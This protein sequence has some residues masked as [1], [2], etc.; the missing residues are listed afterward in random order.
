[1]DAIRPV[2]P[3]HLDVVIVGA[4]LSGIGCAVHLS[5]RCPDH[6]Y[7]ILEARERMGGTWDLFRYPGIRSDSDMYTL[8]YAFRPWTDGKAIAD[9]P[10]ILKYIE[11]TAREFSVDEKI[12]Y[13]LRLERASW[14]TEDAKWTLFLREASTG[15]VRRMTCRFLL[16]CTGYYDYDQAHAPQFEG[17]GDFA[18]RVV[19]P[20]FW[21]EDIDYAGK[22]VVVI[23]SGATAMT[24]VPSLAE[25]AEHVTMLQRSPTYVVAAPDTDAVA[26]F[27]RRHLSEK[28]AYDI[29]RWKNV[30]RTIAL[31]KASRRFPKAMKKLFIYGVKKA[32]GEDYDVEKHFTPSYNPWDQRLCLVPNG[33]LFEAIKAGTASVATD[34]IERFTERG[35]RLQSGEE[36]EADLIVTATGLKVRLF[37]GAELSVDGRAITPNDTMAYRAMMVSD[38]PNLAFAVGYTNAS[39][40]LKIDL[41]ADYVA[42]LLD[43]MDANGYDICVPERDPDM[44]QAP[45]LDFDANYIKR[46]LGELPQAGKKHPW[47]IFENYLLDRVTLNNAR[48]DDGIMK[49]SKRKVRAVV[50]PQQTPAASTTQRQTVA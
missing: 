38:V 12:R 28:T 50:R 43:H 1:M 35:V 3:E 40:T 2:D 9:G 37:G 23:G 29:T 10:S 24:L 36:L 13:G 46:A 19:H 15:E 41:V 31:Y 47:R 17:Q 30:L 39:W 11:D 16:A 8:G 42:R 44:E 4:G 6:R 7:A 48:F 25:Q 34:H 27:L 5:K 32:L 21:T 22:K 33:D 14:S 26:D 18:G 45:L 49:F 20:Q